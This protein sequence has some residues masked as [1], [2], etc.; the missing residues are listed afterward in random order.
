M[1]SNFRDEFYFL[2]NFYQAPITYNGLIYQNNEAAF[3][4]QKNIL[5]SAEFINLNPSDAKKTW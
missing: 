3:H 4:A 2:S 5:R 1:I